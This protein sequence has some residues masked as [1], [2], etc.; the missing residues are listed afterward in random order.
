MSLTPPATLETQDRFTKC[1]FTLT[2][3]G[4]PTNTDAALHPQDAAAFLNYDVYRLSVSTDGDANLAQLPNEL[5]AVKF[6]ASRPVEVFLRPRPRQNAQ[7]T[8]T[9][10]AVSESDPTKTATAKF[11]LKN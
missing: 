9:L 11:T 7:T 8:I 1:T 5:A 2:N 3:T 10:T 6:G 4:K